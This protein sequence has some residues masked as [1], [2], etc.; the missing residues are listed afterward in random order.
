MI[1]TQRGLRGKL[2]PLPLLSPRVRKACCLCRVSRLPV[3]Q[4]R[5][6]RMK[7]VYAWYRLQ[8][9]SMRTYCGTKG[10]CILVSRQKLLSAATIDA[11]RRRGCGVFV[12]APWAISLL[13]RNPQLPATVPG[14]P[15]RRRT[16]QQRVCRLH[17]TRHQRGGRFQSNLPIHNLK[18][19]NM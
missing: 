5:G 13:P 17:R 4:G 1:V 14:H 19:G 16:L 6:R 8:A 10:S 15:R 12:S 18:C 3:T 11:R 7:E 9:L 2:L